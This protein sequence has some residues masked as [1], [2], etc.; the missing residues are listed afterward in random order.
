MLHYFERADITDEWWD[1][2]ITASHQRIIY[3]YSWYLDAV[4]ETWGALVEKGKDQYVSVFPLPIKRRLGLSQVYQPFF[5][6]QLGLFTTS[7]SQRQSLPDYL[8]IIPGSFRKVFLQLNTTNTFLPMQGKHGFRSRPRITHHLSLKKAYPQLEQAYSTN[9]KRNLKKAREHNYVVTLADDVL[10][11]LHLF[12]QNKGKE[13]PELGDPDYLRLQQVY[14]QA[15]GLEA[16]Q[17]LEIRQEKD[18]L[19]GA[20]FLISP[21]K[22]IFLFGAAS[23]E[24]K[25]TGAMSLLLDYLIQQRA[26][27]GDI[28]DF[29]GSEQAGVARFYA[30]FGGQPQT[31]VSLIRNNLPWY[32]KWMVKDNI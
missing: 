26:G 8:D 19:A 24:A 25:K 23:A 28:L 29:E 6:Q 15:K 20:F 32:L 3:A 11:L 12:R 7:L 22:L 9:L 17:L 2:C 31:Y 18:L 21:G 5:T 30:S 27:S 10:P 16:A 4:C 1:A 13:L 14:T